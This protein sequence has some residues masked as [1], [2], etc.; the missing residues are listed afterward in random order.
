MAT[1]AGFTLDDFITEMGQVERL[2]RIGSVWKL[3]L[4]PTLSNIDE[5]MVERQMR[6][7]RG[8]YNAL[9]LAER[10]N[11]ELVTAAR[12]HRVARG[13]G[14]S[15]PE[16]GQFLAQFEQSRRMMEY[17]GSNPRFRFTRLRVVLGLVTSD[18][19]HRD[20]SYTLPA[21]SFP[22]TFRGYYL[23][24]ILAAVAA[25]VIAYLATRR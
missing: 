18:K 25:L 12:R 13:A 11:P 1:N 14:V 5:A 15:V 8:M 9:T 19:R 23:N 2:G 16:V 3:I 6:R 22:W 7:M 17:A 24:V 10:A 20:P 21:S 4:G